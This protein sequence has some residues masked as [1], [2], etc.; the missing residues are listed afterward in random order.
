M[1]DPPFVEF[2]AALLRG[3]IAPR[4]VRRAVLELEDHWTA[5]VAENL[6]RGSSEL[7]ARTEARRIV[8]SD[9]LVNVDFVVVA[10]A[11]TRLRAR[12][13]SDN[14]VFD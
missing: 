10:I 13:C 12:R 8:G 9:A 11:L 2:E 6:R 1:A 3:G 4:H 7:D 5:L 14:R